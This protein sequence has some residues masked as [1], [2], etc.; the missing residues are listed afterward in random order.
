MSL[1]AF[2]KLGNQTL[3]EWDESHTAINAIEMLQNGDYVNL[4]YVG[5]PDEIRAKPPLFIWIVATSFHFF[6]ANT[7]SLRLPSA[8]FTILAFFFIFKIIYL[9]KPA[10]FAFFTGLILV[11]VK[12]IIGY[13]VGRTGDFDA[14]LVACLLG[15]LYYFLKYLDFNKEKAIYLAALFF[16]L[17][18]MTKGPAMGVLFPGMGLYV[19]LSKRLEKL[20]KMPNFWEAVGVSLLFPIGWFITL[21]LYGVATPQSQYAGDNAFERM[22]LYDLL[23]RFTSTDFEN[24][25]EHSDALFFFRCMEESFRYWNYVFYVVVL[26]G[27][28]RFFFRTSLHDFIQNRFRTST[29]DIHTLQDILIR[30]ENRLPLLSLCMWLPLAIFLSMVTTAKWWYMAPVIPF[31]AVTTYYGVDWLQQRYVVVKYLFLVM[32]ALTLGKRYV[33]SLDDEPRRLVK[34]AEA[35]CPLVKSAEQVLFLDTL[36]RQDV[37]GHLYF[38]NPAAL[39]KNAKSIEDLPRPE[40]SLVLVSKSYYDKNLKNSIYYKVILDDEYFVLLRYVL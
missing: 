4:Y 28:Y 37:L 7:F 9:Y 17:A 6:G 11:A 38:C 3:Y 2:L 31:I 24:Q 10:R 40:N 34:A 35:Y 30:K 5:A 20:I 36:P 27:I 16:G 14:M 22:F 32:L 1:A 12:G 29:G 33:D 13:H 39:F 8:L 21:F 25:R 26:G 23:E 18:F 15:G 19:L